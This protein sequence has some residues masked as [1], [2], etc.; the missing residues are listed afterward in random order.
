VSLALW[1]IGHGARS[2]AEFLLLLA[3]HRIGCVADV[4]RAPHSRRHP[5]F[6]RDAL[7]RSLAA[8]GTV[9]RHLPGLGGMREPD[10][11]PTNAGIREPAFRGYADFMQTPAFETALSDLMTLATD[12]RTAMLC[13]ESAPEHCHRSMIADALLV[14]G[15]TVRHIVG[16]G[17]PVDHVLTRHARAEGGRVS[18]PAAQAD[19][20]LPES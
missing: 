6:G 1:T 5:H 15:V 16:R 8:A 19:L 14:R 9:Y 12:Q 10:G 11:S 7:A 2:L 18:Y 3:A 13:A 17:A 4:R 20:G